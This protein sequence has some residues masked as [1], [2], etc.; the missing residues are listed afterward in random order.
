M[1]GSGQGSGGAGDGQGGGGAGGLIKIAGE[2][3]NTRDYPAA[4]RDLRIGSSVI[5]ALTVGTDG[6]PTACR[7]VR[8][9]RDP[10]AD[11][12]TCRLALARFRFRPA[13]N[14][15]GQPVVATY[16]WQQRWFY[17]GG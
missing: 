11:A 8:P 6:K 10:D 17:R 3:N 9:S 16:G 7:V 15:A 12:I 14:A 4:T 1:A 5:I 13:T 2:I